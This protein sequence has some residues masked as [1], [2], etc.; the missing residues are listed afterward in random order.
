MYSSIRQLLSL[1]YTY[2]GPEARGSI[3][4]LW[5]IYISSLLFL[6]FDSIFWCVCVCKLV[7]FITNNFLIVEKRNKRKIIH[8]KYVNM[9]LLVRK[10]IWSNAIVSFDRIDYKYN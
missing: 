10:K 8:I 1:I 9:H 6:H 3:I 5:L 7:E 4:H 2:I